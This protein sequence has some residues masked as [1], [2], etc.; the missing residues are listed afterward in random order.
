MPATTSA[1]SR[2]AAPKPT[3][4]GAL[5]TILLAWAVAGTLDVG[6]AVTYYPLTAN[7]TA[8]QILQGIASGVLG[9]RA[10]QG[11]AATAALGLGLHYVIAFIWTVFFYV[12]ATNV[13]A[14]TR[15]PL[16][17]GPLYGTFVWLVMNLIVLPLSHVAHR[18]LRLQPSIIGAVILMIC[19][20]TPIAT[21]VGRHLSG[22][23]R[24]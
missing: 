16:I 9:A 2:P 15:R 6:T 20:G 18:P 22:T 23:S 12:L 13:R 19:I 21:I 8:T 10:F 17:V 5:R 24:R 14:L 11:G 7:V 4:T 1:A 3:Q